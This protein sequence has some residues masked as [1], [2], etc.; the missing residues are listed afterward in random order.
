MKLKEECDLAANGLERDSSQWDERVVIEVGSGSTQYGQVVKQSQ[1]VKQMSADS[2]QYLELS[3][4][5]LLDLFDVFH[6]L[7]KEVSESDFGSVAGK[8]K[9]LLRQML[10]ER[11]EKTS[12]ENETRL[13][14][15]EDVD[16]G[17]MVT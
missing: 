9:R 11:R 5:L 10:R 15:T 8:D 7:D 14:V 16:I 12:R 6:P 1:T 3:E 4:T 2:F 17:I 13:E